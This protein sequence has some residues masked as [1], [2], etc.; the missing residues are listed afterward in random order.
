MSGAA[1]G[2]A[3]EPLGA[4]VFAP[5]GRVLRIDDAPSRVVNEGRAVR[6]ELGPP[7][8]HHG[9]AARPAAALF[10][11]EPSPGPVQLAVAERH[12]LSE[13]LFWPLDVARWLAVV[14][15]AGADGGP[16]ASGARAFVAGPDVCLIYAPGVWHAP[17]VALD[18]RGLLAMRMVESGTADD[19]HEVRLAVPVECPV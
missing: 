7:L 2:L 11:I 18:R 10:A 17:L 3:P 4:D 9:P 16:D 8:L 14:F 15:P 19:C 6:R 12:P 5:F 1:R 13:Q